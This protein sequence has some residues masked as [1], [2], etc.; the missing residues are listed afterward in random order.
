MKR[1]VIAGNYRQ[2]C[3]WCSVNEVYRRD[4]NVVYASSSERLLGISGAVEVVR[5]GTWYERSDLRE[6]EAS[7]ACIQAKGQ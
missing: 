5:I 3:H 2:F 6:I 7:I 4:P 1:I